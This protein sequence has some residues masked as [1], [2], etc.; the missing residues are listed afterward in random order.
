MKAVNLTVGCLTAA[1]IVSGCQSGRLGGASSTVKGGLASADIGRGLGFVDRAKALRTEYQA[2]EFGATGAPVQWRG[3][4][5][6]RGSVIP[7]PGYR[8]NAVDCRDYTHTI[9]QGEEAAVARGTA[10]REPDGTWRPA[11]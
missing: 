8:V 3:R 5:G 4:R 7:G 2:L 1:L 11:T 10:C 6:R 9:Y